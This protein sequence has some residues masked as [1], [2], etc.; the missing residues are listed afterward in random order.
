MQSLSP[1]CFNYADPARFTSECLGAFLPP[2]RVGTADCAAGL[3]YLSGAYVGR[4]THEKA[5]YLVA[6]MDAADDADHTTVAVP[7]PGQCGKTASVE[8]YLFRCICYDPADVLWYMHTDAAIEDYVKQTINPLVQ[9]HQDLRARLGR[10]RV[11][12]SLSFKRFQGMTARFL[13]FT[14]SNVVNKVAPR[15]IADEFDAMDQSVGDPKTVLDVRRQT[16]GR[17]SKLIALSH[18]D[19]AG[20]SKP[21]E[22]NAGIMSLYRDSDRRIWWWPCPHC[23]LWSSPAPG[24][25]FQTAFAFE[26][27]GE[28]DRVAE[29][30]HLVCPHNGCVIADTDRRGMNARG[31]WVGI[32]QTIDEETG[33]L[34]GE[35]IKT[36]TAGFWIQGVMS[37]F[38]PGGIGWLARNY[39]KAHRNFVATGDAAGLRTVCAKQ[40]GVPFDKPKRHETVDATTLADRAELDL[41]LGA[42]PAFVRFITASMDVQGNRFELLWRGWGIER[43]SVVIDHRVVKDIAGVPVAPATDPAAWD[44][45][46]ALLLDAEFPLAD[47]S[48]RVM[49][50]KAVGVDNHGEDGVTEQG[51]R[52]WQRL[53]KAHRVKFEGTI[54]G[55]RTYNL[56]MLRG[57]PQLNAKNLQVHMPDEQASGK[58][59]RGGV[60]RG[61]FNPGVFKSI[62]AGQLAQAT[63]GPGYVH[64]PHALRAAE[65]P[66]PW[67]EQLT[68]EEKQ[69]NGRWVKR[70]GARNEVLDL[71]VMAAVMAHLHAP[72]RFD[73]TAMQN[74]P[75]WAKP[76]EAN[77]LVGQPRA[78]QPPLAGVEAAPARPAPAAPSPVQP[79]RQTGPAAP[80]LV[81]WATQGAPASSARPW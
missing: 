15:I 63:P 52:A 41:K 14:H 53:R 43:E 73:W 30:A 6:I 75:P 1:P 44:H 39:V 79:A 25:R 42:V 4:W 57:A 7:G 51:V 77:P 31:K 21:S 27:D 46:L 60:P 81:P 5:P 49:R 13:A 55:R 26:T 37:P 45:V 23:D 29:S 68:A 67:F 76:W 50:V 2:E 58:K 56:L 35:L 22:W 38:L 36:D 16:F 28:L 59:A 3:R 17:A 12:N 9:S 74:V 24:A 48:G 71:M 18:P 32:G 62:L 33:D 66:H 72:S 34:S 54:S 70:D 61:D 10:D 40:L 20:G 64:F 19:L 80:V 11:D 69:P 65:A 47:G 8:N 78:P